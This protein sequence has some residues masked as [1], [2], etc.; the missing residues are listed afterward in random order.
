MTITAIDAAGPRLSLNVPLFANPR[1]DRFSH[2]H[3]GVAPRSTSGIWRPFIV[4]KPHILICGV[5]RA[6]QYRAKRSL[7]G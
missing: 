6:Y 3:P 1:R 5:A 2:S 7:P 4:T